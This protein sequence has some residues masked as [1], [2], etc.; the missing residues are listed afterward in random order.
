MVNI[1]VR[2]T[3]SALSNI[4]L[5]IHGHEEVPK[6]KFLKKIMSIGCNQPLYVDI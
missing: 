2:Q 3:D 1:S 5:N 6:K 4:S